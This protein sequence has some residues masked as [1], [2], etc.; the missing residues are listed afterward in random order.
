MART[1]CLV[2]LIGTVSGR[3]KKANN[4]LRRGS[5][6]SRHITKLENSRFSLDIY[7]LPKPA[8]PYD[9]VSNEVLFHLLNSLVVSRNLC[10][11]LLNKI[12]YFSNIHQKISKFLMILN[13]CLFVLKLLW[14][15]SSYLQFCDFPL[16][17]SC[18]TYLGP[19]LP[20]G[21]RIRQLIYPEHL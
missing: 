21:N 19:M 8:I 10:L 17:K 6:S 20:P 18:K 12:H 7:D 16:N 4:A 1:A 5:A 13:L 14:L 9:S 2:C 3:F 11:I 15:F